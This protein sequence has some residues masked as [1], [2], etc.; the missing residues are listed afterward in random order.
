MNYFRNR[1]NR[2]W[3]Y[4]PREQVDDTTLEGAIASAL[5]QVLKSWERIR[6]DSANR[7]EFPTAEQLYADTDAGRVVP[8]RLWLTLDPDDP[9]MDAFVIDRQTLLGIGSLRQ[10]V[11]FLTC[12]QAA[13]RVAAAR[14]SPPLLG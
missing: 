2:V 14:G 7:S 8:V 9:R 5:R 10:V 4:F 6:A 3:R 13:R 11:V 1:L 12:Q